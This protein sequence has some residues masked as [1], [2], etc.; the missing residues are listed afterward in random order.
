[1]RTT[2][3][4]GKELSE[5]VGENGKCFVA[6]DGDKVVGVGACRIK[7]FNRWFH[8][9]NAMELMLNAIIPAYQGKHIYPMLHKV[10]IEEAKRQGLDVICC[11]TAEKNTKVIQLYSEMGF[12]KVDFCTPPSKHYSVEMMHWLGGCPFFETYCALR[13]S[14]RKFYVKMRYKPGK[15]KRFVI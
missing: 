3:L 9:G 11:D 10:R 14:L 7:E 13:Y 8:K 4:S 2:T 15:I 5:R 6:M 12:I 1:M